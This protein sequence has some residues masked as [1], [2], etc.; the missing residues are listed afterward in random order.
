MV[1][2]D[3][4]AG[5]RSSCILSLNRAS[6]EHLI[7]VDHVWRKFRKPEVYSFDDGGNLLFTQRCVHLGQQNYFVEGFKKDIFS[8]HKLN[9]YLL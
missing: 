2:E 4:S 8:I 5:V 6:E 1:F 7:P 3:R 9:V